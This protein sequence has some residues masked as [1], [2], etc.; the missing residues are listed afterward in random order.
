MKIGKSQK[1]WKTDKLSITFEISYRVRDQPN[2]YKILVIIKYYLCKMSI[3]TILNAL[4]L[5]FIL[6]SV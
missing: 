1:N 3:K 6:E 2:T 5:D 4:K